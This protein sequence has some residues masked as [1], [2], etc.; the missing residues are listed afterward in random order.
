MG[1]VNWD[2][3]ASVLLTDRFALAPTTLGAPTTRNPGP[4]RVRTVVRHAA[5]Q[6]VLLYF[7]LL[8]LAHPTASAPHGLGHRAHAPDKCDHLKSHGHR[9]RV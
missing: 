8:A 6:E 5:M 3:F 2:G 7:A 1:Q 4:A 9:T